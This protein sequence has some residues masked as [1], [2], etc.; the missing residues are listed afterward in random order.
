MENRGRKVFFSNIKNVVSALKSE[1]S[2]SYVLTMQL[3]GVGYLKV[4]KVKSKTRGRPS[5][6]YIMTNKA[7]VLLVLAENYENYEILFDT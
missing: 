3:V 5:H 1:T 7:K 2:L 6:N 4:K